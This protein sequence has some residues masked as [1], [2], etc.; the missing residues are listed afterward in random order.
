[1]PKRISHNLNIEQ[2]WELLLKK[3]DIVKKTEQNGFFRI[4]ANQIKEYK[5][6]RLM[7]KFDSSDILTKPLK[8][9]KL[10]ILPDSSRSYVIGDFLLYQ[11]IPELTEKVE[12]MTPV[13]LANYETIDI[14][15][16]NSEANAINILLLSGILDD[17]LG[18]DNTVATFNGKM[19]TGVFDFFVNTHKNIKHRIH[20]NKARCEIDGGFENEK[21]IVI[22]EAK[23]VLHKD[24]HIRQLYY[25]YRLWK[26]KVKKPV[27]LI[28]SI[29]SNMIYRLFE[30]RF[31]KLEDFS[32]IELVHTK[33]YSLQD[34]QISLDDLIKVRKTTITTKNDKKKKNST[35]F[36]QADSL[37]RVISL[38]ENM[39]TEPMSYAQVLELM[40]FVS[41]QRQYYVNAGIYLGIFENNTK[42]QTVCLTKTGERLVKMNYKERQLKL[43]SLILEHKIF[44]DLFDFTIENGVIPNKKHVCNKMIE[45]NVCENT[46]STIERRASSVLHWLKWIFNLPILSS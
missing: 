26:S 32:S 27:R 6:P 38:L 1:M 29:Y 21:E 40:N 23:N 43:V 17:F 45:L 16:I 4:T 12:Q 37:D 5:E 19:G 34:I 41:R 31:N 24:F 13:Q 42:K 46:N 39:K 28:F 44:A 20:V 35:P 9:N 14:N 2:A 15:N 10:N 33:N 11:D 18:S 8:N 3:Y 25:P 7:A 30:Y 36:I 22:L